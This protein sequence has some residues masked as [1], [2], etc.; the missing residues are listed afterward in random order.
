M[1]D[2]GETHTTQEIADYMGLSTA[3]VLKIEIIA[4]KKLRHLLKFDSSHDLYKYMQITLRDED[5]DIGKSTTPNDDENFTEFTPRL[6][7]KTQ[8]NI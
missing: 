6:T 1:L 7:I 5:Y 4:L 8:Y 3:T 2:Y